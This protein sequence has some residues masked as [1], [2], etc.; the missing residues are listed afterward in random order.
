MNNVYPNLVAGCNLHSGSFNG[1]IGSTYFN[2]ACFQNPTDGTFGNNPV[3]NPNVRGFGLAT[4]DIGIN[5]YFNFGSEGRYKLNLR[6]DMFNAFIRHGYA[7]PSTAVDDNL[8]VIRDGG[9]TPGGRVGQLG[10]RFTF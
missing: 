1:Q 9:G 8:G 2:P 4:E 5:K 6:F 7:G 3:Y 10:A